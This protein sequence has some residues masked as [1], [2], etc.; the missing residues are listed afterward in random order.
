MPNAQM[1]VL[2]IKQPLAPQLHSK[3]EEAEKLRQSAAEDIEPQVQLK[4]ILQ[5][6]QRVLPESA[7]FVQS[8]RLAIDFKETGM[9]DGDACQQAEELYRLYG[10][11][12]YDAPDGSRRQV[13]DG[14]EQQAVDRIEHED[15]AIVER[16]IDESKNEQQTHAPGKAASEGASLLLLVV[17][18]DKETESEEHSEDAVHLAAQQPGE[19]P[20]YRLIAR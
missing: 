10:Q 15:I 20:A 18:H 1:T 12:G 19:H 3:D 7:M 11:Q 14:D 8:H 13:T 2:V 17:V 5:V 9:V 4:A 16:Y 6:V